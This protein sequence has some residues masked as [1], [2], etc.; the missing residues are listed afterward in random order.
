MKRRPAGGREEL[1]SVEWLRQQ[2]DDT[3]AEPWAIAPKP[4]IRYLGV[5]CGL[6]SLV[7]EVAQLQAFHPRGEIVPLP[8]SLPQLLGLSSVEGKLYPCFS[9]AELLSWD[10]QPAKWLLL[11][12]QAP[13][14][15][16]VDEVLGLC[17]V[18]A[19]SQNDLGD[20]SVDGAGGSESPG[21][22][23]LS[24]EGRGDSPITGRIQHEGT[25]LSVL[26]IPV[27]LDLL[28]ELIGEERI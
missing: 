3:F 8:T 27:V 23:K 15:L 19:Q 11:C 21:R 16:A 6:R 22:R 5:R 7:I 17:L 12:R 26:S 10:A 2:F 13:V 4:Q 25:E 24:M 18:D 28:R 14:A 1:P 9:L 20:T